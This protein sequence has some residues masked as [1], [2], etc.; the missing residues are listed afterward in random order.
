M[1]LLINNKL[2]NKDMRD[3]T[4]KNMLLNNNLLLRNKWNNINNNK[5]N[6]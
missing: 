6:Y 2:L 1:K 4:L 5:V 3:I